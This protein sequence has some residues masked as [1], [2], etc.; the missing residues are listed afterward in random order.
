MFKEGE[1]V[2]VFNTWLDKTMQTKK[3]LLPRWS[4][5]LRITGC[6]L[7]LYM[8]A[9]VAGVPLKGRFH[10]R[11]L[12]RFI[13]PIGSSLEWYE[14]EHKARLESGEVVLPPERSTREEANEYGMEAEEADLIGRE[15]D[16]VVVLEEDSGDELAGG[17]I[18]SIGARVAERHRGVALR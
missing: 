12:Q 18:L 17:E 1:L 5:A 2:Q 13:L 10:V 16:E 4:G 7:N 3:K 9:T 11:W 14:E 15:N 8:V 6:M